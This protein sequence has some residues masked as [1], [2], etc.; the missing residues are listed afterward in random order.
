[1]AAA[2]SLVARRFLVRA[3]A[4]E[5]NER[6]PWARDGWGVLHLSD[7]GDD[8]DCCNGNDFQVLYGPEYTD[9]PAL[10]CRA[11]AGTHIEHDDL[12]TNPRRLTVKPAATAPS[13]YCRCTGG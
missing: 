11:L 1:M 5:H 13:E 7:H 2:E 6:C 4:D 9:L 8:D 10:K 12:S 3:G